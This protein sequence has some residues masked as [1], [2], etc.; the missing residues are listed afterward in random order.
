MSTTYQLFITAL[1][2]MNSVKP[3]ELGLPY[4][5]IFPGMSGILA[6]RQ[7]K[8]LKYQGFLCQ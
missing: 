3:A 4:V 5:R 7:G 1:R 6:L 2:N 8:V